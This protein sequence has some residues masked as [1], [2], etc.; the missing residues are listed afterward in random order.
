MAC[1]YWAK[2]CLAENQLLSS[3]LVCTAVGGLTTSSHASDW[4][5]LANHYELLIGLIDFMYYFI[6]F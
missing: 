2:N 6:F 1:V 3:L 4:F 5:S